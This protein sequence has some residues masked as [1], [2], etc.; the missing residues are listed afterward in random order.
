[1]ATHSDAGY[2]GGLAGQGA[3][4]RCCRAAAAK[5]AGRGGHRSRDSPAG[6]RGARIS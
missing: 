5:T 3:L 4:R 2:G 1:M 6:S